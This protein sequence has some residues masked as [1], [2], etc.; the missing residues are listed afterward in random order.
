[1]GT[2]KSFAEGELKTPNFF[3]LF[4]KAKNQVTIEDVLFVYS[5][6]F[7]LPLLL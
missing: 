7:V 4:K 5:V 3:S 6:V 1:M 2:T